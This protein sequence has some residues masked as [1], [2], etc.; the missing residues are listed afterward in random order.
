MFGRTSI[1]ADSELQRHF[2]PA[3]YPH[4]SPV[5]SRWPP[6]VGSH[7]PTHGRMP[8]NLS[9]LSASLEGR[10]RVEREIGEGGM[11][12]VYLAED[13]KH[14]RK[15]ALKLL[16]PELGAVLGVERFLAEIQTTAG[17]QH[18][19]LLPLFDSG[20]V[21]TGNGHGD[22]SLLFY[23]MPFVEGETL[24]ARLEREKQLPVDEALRIASAIAGALDY[25]HSHG[26][27]HRDLKPENILLQHGQPVVADFG[28][29]LAVS[30]A[31]GA[32][33]TQTGLS[34]GTP[35]YMSPEQAT[36]D[37]AIDARSDIYSLG[38]MTYEML[39]GDPPHVASTAQ[40][41]IAKVLTV[42]PPSVLES[43]P[44]VGDAVAYAVERALE[45]L[46]ADRWSSA[47]EFAD[48]LRGKLHTGAQ[49]TRAT[50]VA[51]SGKSRAMTRSQQLLVASSVAIAIASVGYG[52]Y[53]QYE[54][55]RSRD[56]GPIGRFDVTLPDSVVLAT[57]PGG[58]IA[59]SRDG[60]RIVVVGRAPSRTEAL[61]VR[62]LDDPVAIRV[63]GTEDAQSPVFSPDG[64]WLLFQVAGGIKKVPVAGGV[65]QVVA[66]SGAVPSW[67]DD[68]VVAY[69]HGE[70]LMV[71]TAT[72]RDGRIVATPD[73]ARRIFRYRWP[74]IL[75][76][77][78][79]ALVAVDV[80]PSPNVVDSLRLAV[81][82]LRDGTATE[83]G[84]A[85][86]APK[87]VAPGYIMFAR[88]GGRV[89]V[90][91]FSLQSRKI[92]G[93][94]TLLVDGIFQRD[95]G[96]SGFDI[97]QAGILVV[98]PGRQGSDD[99]RLVVVSRNGTARVLPGEPQRYQ[100]PRLSP[101]GKR[102]AV[103]TANSV[104]SRTGHVWLVDV[105]TGARTRAMVDASSRLPEWTRDGRLVY[106]DSIGGTLFSR[107]VDQPGDA[108]KLGGTNI[109]TY[110]MGLPGGHWVVGD[111]RVSVR[112]PLRVVQ[113]DS[114]SGGRVLGIPGALV[115]A[116]HI[117]PDGMLLA[118]RSNESGRG[119]VMIEPLTGAGSRVVVSQDGGSEPVWAPS[120]RTLYYRAN[121]Y[122]TSAT[123]E[124]R[125]ALRVS[126]RERLFALDTYFSFLDPQYDVFPDEQS[127]LMLQ[128]DAF[129]ETANAL[130]V[131]MNW[132]E[133]L[134]RRAVTN[135][136]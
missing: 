46:P 128:R 104:G 124:T 62:R 114:L 32:R 53:V 25:A 27:V 89:F 81:V 109:A 34:L 120:G 54:S 4:L 17:L 123:I 42:R 88:A 125:P 83:L 13:V 23:V 92:T 5:H 51:S 37:R 20:E 1:V 97:S 63:A 64:N 121:G 74:H 65:P 40:A 58:K 129:L 80:S 47:G 39:V 133:L 122:M 96:A 30:N 72:G 70:N 75:P 98:Q 14:R 116:P 94:A 111:L 118:Y 45:K 6:P 87:Y 31:G 19:N 73:S 78:Q 110:A 135:P 49:R 91:P 29:A 113:P 71:G 35:Q 101:D 132:P 48:A 112:G 100:E 99:L 55:S 7:V 3:D 131:V 66:D 24:R 36:G 76:G 127:F 22:A 11:A 119:Q 41:V 69:Q 21:K 95:G 44:S 136:E 61:Y 102:V 60:S 106:V 105:A 33:V 38:A 134:K 79:H 2:L 26:V 115:G 82:S 50:G 15:V 84:V 56:V 103:S 9:R 43:R 10:Y 12:T 16:K 77:G 86:T 130:R 59:I 107:A 85:G 67:G 18:P 126:R 57:G 90:A 8:D 108:T 117:S 93:R 28:I 52:S 68:D